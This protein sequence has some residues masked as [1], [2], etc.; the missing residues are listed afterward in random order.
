MAFDVDGVTAFTQDEVDAMIA[1][2]VSGLKAKTDE[3]L[4]EAKRAKNALKNYD[5]VDP[6]EFKRLKEAAD[7]AER[8]KA[9]AAGDF[10]ALEKQMAERHTVELSERETK[11]SKMQRALERKVVEAELV[12]AIAVKKGDPDLLLPYARQYARMRETEDDFEGFV[13][14]ERGNPLVADGKGTPMDFSAFVEQHLMAKFPR[15]FEGTGSSGGG[16]P[17]SSAGG[18][19]GGPKRI[20]ANDNNAFI[21]SLKDIANGKVTVDE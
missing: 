21:S 7:Q 19:G 18:G 6:A 3:L 16:A 20:S 10:K 15:A 8:D 1:E 13:S 12:R 14:D 4:T 9:A 11:I 2:Q 5:G 17:R